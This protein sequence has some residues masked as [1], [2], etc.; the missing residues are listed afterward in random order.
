[1]II[2]EHA[3]VSYVS[4]AVETVAGYDPAAIRD[5]S[6]FAYVHDAD[7]ELAAEA[8]ANTLT[9]PDEAVT[10][11]FRIETADGDLR[12][13][14]AR[15]RNYLDEPLIDGLLVSVRDITE[16]KRQA[17]QFTTL[18][19]RS[20]DLLTVVDE[21][22]DIQYQSPSIS[23]VLGYDQE[24]LVGDRVTEY[25]HPDDEAD[26]MARMSDAI[27]NPDETVTQTPHG[28]VERI[29]EVVAHHGREVVQPLTWR[30][31]RRSFST[32]AVMSR[33]FTTNPSRAGFSS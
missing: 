17:A 8:F 27:A 10:V 32:N 21:S 6:A 9:D 11:E 24:E 16:R 31:S 7:H 15:G 33:L 4:P 3:A 20:S 26:V 19:E 13:V 14:E 1:M 5:T 12:W 2:D 28:D 29:A 22:G 25:V 30:S 18:V 23:R